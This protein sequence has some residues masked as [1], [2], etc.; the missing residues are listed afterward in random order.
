MLKSFLQ[1][2]YLGP[3]LFFPSAEITT[4]ANLL[5][6]YLAFYWK[7]FRYRLACRGVVLNP[8]HTTE[9][10]PGILP[11]HCSMVLQNKQKS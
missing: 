8:N 4:E 5:L 10:K 6:L 7:Y 1:T 11:F 3:F 2:F 9:K